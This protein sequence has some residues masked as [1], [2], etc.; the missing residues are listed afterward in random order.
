MLKLPASDQ[1]FRAFQHPKYD[2]MIQVASRAK[3]GVKIP[4]VKRVRKRVIERW[5]SHLR[6]LRKRLNVCAFIQSPTFSS[7]PY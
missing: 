2:E 3:N 5:I 7:T 4:P 1:P 6:G